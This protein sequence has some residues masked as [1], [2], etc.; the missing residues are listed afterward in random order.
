MSVVLEQ[1]K[2]RTPKVEIK[3][4]GRIY[5]VA[6]EKGG[7]GKTTTAITLVESFKLRGMDAIPVEADISNKDVQLY[8]DLP[9]AINLQKDGGYVNLI[10]Y[11]SDLDPARDVVVSLPAGL[12]AG[13][14]HRG[15]SFYPALE[16][17]PE[18]L[19]REMIILWTIDDKLLSVK[20]L[21]RAISKI[22]DLRIDV[23]KN[24]FYFSEFEDFDS[25]SVRSSILKRGK[26]IILP[27][28][29]PTVMGM[30]VDEYKGYDKAI[31]KMKFGSRIELETWFKWLVLEYQAA[32][33]FA[34]EMR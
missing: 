4:R 22:P 32:G 6:G 5:L 31:S 14:D 25:S 2:R 27:R 33:Y 24:Q 10:D 12:M 1:P 9:G 3:Y 7:V 26:E 28:L 21:D 29:N 17:M 34:G 19:D 20:Q 13:A 16:R 8:F 18:A 30:L 15:A 11:L 23:V